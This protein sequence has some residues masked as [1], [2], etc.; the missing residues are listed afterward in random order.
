[1][2]QRF[3]SVAC[4]WLQNGSQSLQALLRERL[5]PPE[6]FA[7]AGPKAYRPLECVVL[8]EEV[9]ETLFG[10]FA[11]HR[12]GSRGE[13]EI[14]WVLLGIREEN[15][16]LVLATLPAGADRQ[17]GVAHVSFNS[18][19]QA[20][21]SRI[22]RQVD[23]RLGIVGVVHTHPGSLRHPSDGDYQGDILWVGQLRGGEGAFGIGTAD[24]SPEGMHGALPAHMQIEGSLCLSWYVLGANDARY[25]KLAVRVAPGPDLARPLHPL[26]A[27]LEAHA[28]P[29]D[30]L[31]RQL[32]RSSFDVVHESETS[33]LVFKVPLVGKESSLLVYVRPHETRFLLEQHGE[34]ADLGTR[35][36]ELESAVYRLLAELAQERQRQRSRGMARAGR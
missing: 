15:E 35:E 16:V 2:L 32:V 3:A 30:L 23:R 11:S 22:V 18:E 12:R 27:V 24:G 7:G 1:M 26:W 29:L 19:A 34:L 13:E 28:E 20:L 10:D 25:R 31:C 21:A 9:Y 33:I 14:G 4:R 17:A 36:E 6:L 5:P 8:T